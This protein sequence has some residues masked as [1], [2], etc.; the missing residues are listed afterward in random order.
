M[1]RNLP[2]SCA[3]A[4]RF[5][6]INDDLDRAR[7]ADWKNICDLLLTIIL[8]DRRILE[9]GVAIL[10]AMPTNNKTSRFGAMKFRV[11]AVTNL[12]GSKSKEM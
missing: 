9:T 1:L 8:R 6:F 11:L 4:R 2:A 5:R 7:V 3:A 12:S 10:F